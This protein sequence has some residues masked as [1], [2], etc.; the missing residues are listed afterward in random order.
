MDLL[1]VHATLVIL[2]L[3]GRHLRGRE[4]RPWFARPAYVAAALLIIAVMELLA[5]DGRTFHYLGVSPNPQSAD[6]SDRRLIDTLAAMTSTAPAS[7]HSHRH[8]IGTA[9]AA[10]H[11]GLLLH[12]LAV[13]HS[14]TTRLPGPNRRVLTALRLD[15]PRSSRT[16][17]LSSARRGSAA[18]LLRRRAEYRRGALSDCQ[19]PG[20]V[21]SPAMGLAVIAAGLLAL[22]AGFVHRREET[23]RAGA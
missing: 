3:T 16:S 7:T 5:L 4:H 11:G 19:S 2:S 13:C 8:S 21:R 23:R 6:V 20:L 14:A 22:A 10:D 9:R 15:L 12:A 17:S 18:P 1:A